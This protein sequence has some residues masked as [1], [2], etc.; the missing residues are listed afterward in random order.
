MHTT[1][2]PIKFMLIDDE[3]LALM[4]M[5]KEL[6]LIADKLGET[7]EI[8]MLQLSERALQEVGRERPDVVFLDIHM[9]EVS[10]LQIAELLQEEYPSIMLVFMTAHDNYAL[11]AF[12]L[13][14][15]DYVLKP[16]VRDRLEKTFKRIVARMRSRLNDEPLVSGPINHIVMCAGTLLVRSGGAA[17]ELPKWRTAKAQELFAYLLMRRETMVH[18]STLL[19]QFFPELDKKSAMTRLYTTIY[20][21]RQ[22]LQSM[23]LDIA[24]RNVSMQEGYILHIGDTVTIDTELWERELL[25]EAERDP[26]DDDRIG[27]LLGEYD[28]GFLSDHDYD[29][30]ESERMRLG[31]LW[32]SHARRLAA[33]WEEQRRDEEAL[34]LYARLQEKDPYHEGDAL[35]ILKLYDRLGQYDKVVAYAE[36]LERLFQEELDMPLPASIAAWRE[37]WRSRSQPSAGQ[38]YPRRAYHKKS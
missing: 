23:D 21:I 5:E 24:I 32:M 14:A 25:A 6:R 27:E 34:K 30:A 20:Q 4:L 11:E 15:I 18:K 19:E 1:I 38:G 10:G 2:D 8:S 22:C 26:A 12:E 35:A 33:M 9:P 31:V 28:G 13:N 3:R 7:V 29:W 17:P 16:L 36:G 37:G